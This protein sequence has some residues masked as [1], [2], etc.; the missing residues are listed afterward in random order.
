MQ[1][2]GVKMA[3]LIFKNAAP[4]FSV[5]LGMVKA[6]VTTISNYSNICKEIGKRN[7]C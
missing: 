7:L 5:R 1:H 3:V 4:I 6:E 2:S